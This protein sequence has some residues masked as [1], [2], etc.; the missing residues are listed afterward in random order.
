MPPVSGLCQAALVAAEDPTALKPMPGRELGVDPSIRGTSGV[1]PARPNSSAQPSPAQHWDPHHSPDS[2]ETTT[3]IGKPSHL[4]GGGAVDEPRLVTRKA[5]RMHSHH[6]CNSG[7][8]LE[9]RDAVRNTTC[10]FRVTSIVGQRGRDARHRWVRGRDG[11][12]ATATRG[13]GDRYP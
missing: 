8:N 6:S 9:L 7:R 11:G 10:L 5:Y 2:W 12:A 3:Q 4:A 13:D 1:P